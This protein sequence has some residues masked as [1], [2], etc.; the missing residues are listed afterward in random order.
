MANALDTK[1]IN[2]MKPMNS[3]RR[4]SALSLLLAV[5]L[6]LSA[7]SKLT[8]DNL[9]KVHNGM[10]TADVKAILGEPTS[11][12]TSSALG[13]ISGTTY[14]YHTDT[15]D[16]KITFVNDKVISTEGEFK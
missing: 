13:I 15:S 7:C 14:T 16:V 3:L 11:S 8:E 9:E 6:S 2:L 4:A 12:D 10:S 1:L 5:A